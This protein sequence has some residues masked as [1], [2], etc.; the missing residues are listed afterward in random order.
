MTINPPLSNVQAEL[1]K[2]IATNIPD[3]Q[4]LELKNMIA[5]YL[6]DKA[7]DNADEIWDKNGYTDE[8]FEQLINEKQFC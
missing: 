2:L 3:D 6:L 8:S 5:K 7:R 4:L 1:L